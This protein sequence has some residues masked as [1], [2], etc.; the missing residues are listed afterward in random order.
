VRDHPTYDPLK[1]TSPSSHLPPPQLELSLDDLA[2][3]VPSDAPVSNRRPLPPVA[4]DPETEARIADECLATIGGRPR[5]SREPRRGPL[6]PPALPPLRPARTA[7]DASPDPGSDPASDGALA[8]R[9]LSEGV[10]PIAVLSIPPPS[11]SSAVTITGRLLP[12][13]PTQP[14]L[15]CEDEALPASLQPS[16]TSISYA[17]VALPPAAAG[18]APPP[19][20][21]LHRAAWV[22]AVAVGIGA[23]AVGAVRAAPG[24]DPDVAAAPAR[25]SAP[26]DPTNL[27]SAIVPL[28]EADFVAP[29]APPVAPLAPA[30][31]PTA[32]APARAAAPPSPPAHARQPAAP[33]RPPPAHARAPAAT[34][35]VSAPTPLPDG[36]L[37]LAGTTKPAAAP[38]AAAAPPIAGSNKKPLTPAELIEAQLRAAAR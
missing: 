30:P 10:D 4:C 20:S 13:P 8:L 25:E 28:D 31:R 2:N 1:T 5:A 34:P 14:K 16:T 27:P 11:P 12:D 18:S 33:V 32:V 7:R 3:D 6:P 19:R 37:G 35:K 38:P 15:P 36:S 29:P 22:M 23:L 9:Y 17:P 26:V 21:A 24:I